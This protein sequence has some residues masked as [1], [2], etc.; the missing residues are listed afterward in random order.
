MLKGALHELYVVV[1]HVL[2]PQKLM[3]VKRIPRSI[4]EVF[5]PAQLAVSFFENAPT[6]VGIHICR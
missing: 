6:V 1:R 4:S 3:F 5:L 2:S